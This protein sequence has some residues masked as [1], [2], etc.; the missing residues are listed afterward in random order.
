MF[1]EL[2]ELCVILFING[3]FAIMLTISLTFGY[4]VD[5]YQKKKE[6]R[7]QS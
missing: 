4:V 3:E 5:H 6:I 7:K 2:I 1:Y